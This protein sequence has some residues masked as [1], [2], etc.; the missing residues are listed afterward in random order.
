MNDFNFGELINLLIE[1]VDSM[2]YP[3]IFFLMALESTVVPIPSELV[4]PVAGYLIQQGRMDFGLTILSGATGSLFG[5]YLNYFASRWLG[6]AL[7][8]KYGRYVGL[9]AEHLTKVERFFYS[10]GDISTFVGRLLPVVRHLISIPAG[11]AR[12]GH[13]RFS[14][15]TGV[16]SAIWATVLTAIG[17]ILGE[18]QDLVERYAHQAVICAVAFSAILVLLYIIAH[19]W[20]LKVKAT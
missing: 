3:G 2:G 12:M 14:T 5:A 9:N 19:R 1:S 17:F 4:M 8:L 20:R 7:V 16:G 15:Y 18:R 6:R 13:L 10:H 11:L